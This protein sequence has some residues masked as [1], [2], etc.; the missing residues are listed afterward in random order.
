M[1]PCRTKIQFY[2]F[3]QLCMG[4]VWIFVLAACG[5]AAEPAQHLDWSHLPDYI[6]ATPQQQSSRKVDI[7]LGRR[8]FFSPLLSSNGQLSCASCHGKEQYFQDGEKTSSGVT[9]EALLRNSPS[10]LN[11]GWAR[12][13]TWS[14][15]AFF[16]LERHMVVPLF[17]DTPPEMSARFDNRW[18]QDRIVQSPELLES[19]AE[20]PDLEGPSSLTWAFAIEAIATYMRS[21]VSFDSAWDRFAQGEASALSSDALAGR[22]LF[23]SDALGCASCHPPPFFSLAYRNGAEARPPV[24]EVHR[25]NGLYFLPG[26]SSGYPVS[27]P[28]VM[29]FSGDLADGGRFRIPSLRNVAVTGPYMHDGSVESLSDVVDLYARGGR[30]IEDGEQQGDGANH[31][32]RDPRIKGFALTPIQRKQLLAFLSSLTGS[33]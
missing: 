27:D 30:M 17:G 9:G 20:H 22:E 5:E 3:V 29:E 31:P 21:L 10:L 25:N 15:L 12:Y 7:E 18:L 33:G 24:R 6:R 14:N 32:N 26:S 23:F 28:G 16:E 11:V 1:L 2:A 13:I 8:L 4:C 19:V